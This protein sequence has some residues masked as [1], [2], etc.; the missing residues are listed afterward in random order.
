MNDCLFCS[1]A[2]GDKANLIWENDIAVA[3][4]DIHPKAPVHVLVVPK[5]HVATLD[6]LD[7]EVLAGRLVTAAREVARK[8][9]IDQAYRFHINSGRAAGQIID[10]VHIHL[11]GKLTP[12]GID[13]LRSEGL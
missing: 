6:E 1:I 9:G 10:H 7:D 4:K 3:F 13:D 8:L 11:L 5:Q 12:Q 2:G